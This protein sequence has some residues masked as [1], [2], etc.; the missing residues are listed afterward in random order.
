MPFFSCDLKRFLQRAGRLSPGQLRLLFE[1]SLAA[2]LHIQRHRIVHRDIKADNVM[3]GLDAEAKGED[4]A[5]R[6]GRRGARSE[7]SLTFVLADFG[8]AMDCQAYGLTDF[9]MPYPPWARDMSLGGAAAFRA[10]EVAKA[11]PGPES[12]IDFCKASSLLALPLPLSLL[13]SRPASLPRALPPTFP[14]CLSASLPP[15]PPSCVPLCPAALPHPPCPPP[16][17]F[18]LLSRRTCSRAA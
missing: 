9:K 16:P 14:P 18:A 13:C 17:S 10:P 7:Q 8:E 12:V 4:G 6:H 1:H 15:S 11:K 2:V 3:V 5:G